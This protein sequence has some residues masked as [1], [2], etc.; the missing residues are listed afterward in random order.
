MEVRLRQQFL[1]KFRIIGQLPVEPEA[2]PFRLFDV[3]PLEGLSVVAVVFA[4]GGVPHVANRGRTRQALHPLFKF[5][6]LIE[7]EHLGDA[8][9]VLVR[10]QQFVAFRVIAGHSRRKLPA[11]LD[12]QQQARHETSRVPGLVDDL[13]VRFLHARNHRADGVS[14]EVINGHDSAFMMQFGHESR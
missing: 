11:V 13:P 2:E 4:T 8:A 6:G 1:T 3:R 14:G 12:I 9:H 5:R 10:V 7:G